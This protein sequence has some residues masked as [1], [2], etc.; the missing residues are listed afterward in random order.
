[1]K[2]LM[3]AT[4]LIAAG[5]AVADVTSANI[6]GYKENGLR[7]GQS[8]LAPCFIDVGA[9]E[10]GVDIL[11]LKPT[12]NYTSGTIII[13]K[14]SASGRDIA[15]YP[16]IKD[17]KGNWYWAIG[18]TAIKEG[19]VVLGPGEGVSV[20]GDNG[21]GVTASG[22]VSSK[23]RAI[24]LRFGQTFTG[25]FTAAPLDITKIVPGGNY[26]SGTIIISRLSA[27]GRDIANYPFIKDRKGNWYWAIGTTKIEEGE[28]VFEPGEGFS[29]TGDNGLTITIPGPTLN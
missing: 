5:V 14:L 9:A 24:P 19:E 20:T 12:G 21:L 23:D 6:V 1:M 29:V 28:V 3:F 17:R 4:A 7:M 18:T 10:E 2:K 25:N 16:F 15:N 27:S 13:S 11:N 22:E 8:F 26:T